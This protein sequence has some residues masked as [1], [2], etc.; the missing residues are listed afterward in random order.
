MSECRAPTASK[1]ATDILH[2]TFS[3][4]YLATHT[5][6]GGNSNKDLTDQDVVQGVIGRPAVYG[7]FCRYF[8]LC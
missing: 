8:C 6:A 1:M 7:V 4:S 3:L 5:I 2:G